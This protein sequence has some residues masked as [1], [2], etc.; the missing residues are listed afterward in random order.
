MCNIDYRLGNELTRVTL[1]GISQ[2]AFLQTTFWLPVA[3]SI[4]RQMWGP[5]RH[6]LVII[7]TSIYKNMNYLNWEEFFN[8]VLI[9]GPANTLWRRQILSSLVSSLFNP[10]VIKIFI[11]SHVFDIFF[12]IDSHMVSPWHN[13]L[14]IT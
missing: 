6:I 14:F 13:I 10:T 12:V 4:F 11:D 5:P 9:G 7:M 2:T 1:D 3:K 8:A